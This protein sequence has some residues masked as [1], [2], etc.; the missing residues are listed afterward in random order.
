MRV[1]VEDLKQISLY[2]PVPLHSR[3]FPAIAIRTCPARESSRRHLRKPFCC[4]RCLTFLTRSRL[5][6]P[7]C[8]HCVLLTL[9]V[10]SAGIPSF[11]TIVQKVRASALMLFRPRSTLRHV[12][13]AGRE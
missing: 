3:D 4:H 5:P 11:S 6:H 9:C 1:Q 2:D 7:L 8:I 13:G 12:F 10:S